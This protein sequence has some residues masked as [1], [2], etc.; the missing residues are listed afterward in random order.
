MNE[1]FFRSSLVISS[2][3]LSSAELL[4]IF[5]AAK[6]MEKGSPMSSAPGSQ[7]R[8]AAV[9]KRTSALPETSSPAEHATEFIRFLQAKYVEIESIRDQVQIDMW[10]MVSHE[11]D[12]CGFSFE[13]DCLCSL[14]KWG[15]NLVFDLYR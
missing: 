12:Q 1:N 8:S 7:R 5:G 3:I 2:E 11:K 15:V 9:W 10:F 13:S 6:V 14:S 4:R